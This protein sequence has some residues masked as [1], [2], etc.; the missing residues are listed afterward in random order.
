MADETLSPISAPKPPAVNPLG[1]ATSTHA[2]TLKLRPV[3]RKPT[4]GGAK[5]GFRP[6]LKLPTQKGLP[7]ASKPATAPEA[8]SAM[9]Q[10]KGMTQKL[11]GATQQI[12][13]QAILRKTGIIADETLTEAQKQAS[14]SRTARISLSDAIGVAPVQNEAAPMNTIRIKRP[15][16]PSKPTVSAPVTPAP[17]EA[18]EAPEVHQ[19]AAP[20]PTAAV[21]PSVTQRKTLKVSR[22]GV[23]PTA[24]SKLT[25]KRPGAAPVAQPAAPAEGEVADIPQGEV[26]AAPAAAAPGVAPAPVDD[27]NRIKD[28]PIGLQVF[29]L[30]LQIAACI[31]IGYLGYL[32]YLDCEAQWF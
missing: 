1:A 18:P 27:R 29:D 22:P 15:T 25:L 6:G 11:K 31:A 2:S 9:D 32:L 3:I 24:G 10:L 20:Q 13:Q 30:I 8:P 17:A 21:S 19:E 7:A 23:R 26:A 16:A 4:I 14:K 5:P 12:P 28:V